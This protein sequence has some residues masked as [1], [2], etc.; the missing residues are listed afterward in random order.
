MSLL[1]FKDLFVTGGLRGDNHCLRVEGSPACMER[2]ICKLSQSRICV[3]LKCSSAGLG[4]C[5]W[6]FTQSLNPGVVGSFWETFWEAFGRPFG[7]PFGRSFGRSFGR[8]FGRALGGLLGS[9][10][11]CAWPF[12]DHDSWSDSDHDSWS[13]SDTKK[14]QKRFF[15]WPAPIFFSVT[16]E[17]VWSKNGHESWSKNGH[18]IPE[19]ERARILG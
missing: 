8:P 6:E 9:L 4:H 14:I 19:C 5:D 13:D 16:C 1:D 3:N 17:N 10:L 7:K 11:E 2:G 18:G 15:F 12:F